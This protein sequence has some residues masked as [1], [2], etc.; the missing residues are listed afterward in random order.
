MR[1][2]IYIISDDPEQMVRYRD[3]LQRDC[4]QDGK[5]YHGVVDEDGC[6]VVQ[7][8]HTL[9]TMGTDKSGRYDKTKMKDVYKIIIE[10]DGTPSIEKL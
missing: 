1:N 6:V 2:I 8:M 10:D 4:T 3:K 5:Q 7:S 9:Q